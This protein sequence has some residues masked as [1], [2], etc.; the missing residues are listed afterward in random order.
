M[1][2]L[3][4]GV[5]GI[6]SGDTNQDGGIDLSDLQLVENDAFN[7][8]YIITD[9]TGDGGPDLSDLQIIENNSQLF[10]FYARP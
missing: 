9:C 6:Y 10:L 8:G 3:G 4:G 5:Y 2:S 7:F 1:K